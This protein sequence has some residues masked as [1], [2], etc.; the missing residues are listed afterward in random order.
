MKDF[1]CGLFAVFLDV[2]FQESI[3][4]EMQGGVKMI[5]RANVFYIRI[6]E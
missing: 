5:I 2:H 4:D 6:R 3:V 1:I